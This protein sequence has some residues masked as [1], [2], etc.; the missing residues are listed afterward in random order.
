M[1][2]DWKKTGKEIYV[3][4]RYAG[5]GLALL[6]KKIRYKNTKFLGWHLIARYRETG[7]EQKTQ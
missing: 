6:C 4:N 3:K 2:A 7:V 1:L 5:F